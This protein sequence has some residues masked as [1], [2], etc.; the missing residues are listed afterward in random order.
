MVLTVIGLLDISLNIMFNKMLMKDLPICWTFF[1]KVINPRTV[2]MLTTSQDLTRPSAI[3]ITKV[4]QNRPVGL[5]YNTRY[6]WVSH[7]FLS[8]NRGM[9]TRSFGTYLEA[10]FSRR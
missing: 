8:S 5:C 10:N 4:A 9:T 6:A 1:T 2:Y 3:L 7:L